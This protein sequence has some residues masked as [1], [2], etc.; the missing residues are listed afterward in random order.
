VRRKSAIRSGAESRILQSVRRSLILALI[1]AAAVLLA[2]AERSLPP[3]V[4]ADRL[5]SG[6]AQWIW[7][8]PDRQGVTPLAFEAARDFE[9]AAPPA[10]ARIHVLADEEYLLH[11]NGVRVGSNRYRP[12]AGVDSYAVAPLLVSGTNRLLLELR[13]GRR[14]GGLLLRL[15]GSDG[16]DIVSGPQWR[17]LLRHRQRH[18]DPAN[19]LKEA[20]RPW[21]WGA[22]PIG[23]WRL[24]EAGAELPLYA[25]AV[26]GEARL[27]PA[28]MG[29]GEVGRPARELLPVRRLRPSS[30]SLGREVTFDWGREVDGYVGLFFATRKWPKA[31]LYFGCEPPS[32]EA[33]P[34]DHALGARGRLLWTSALPRRFRC[35][36][37][38]APEGVRGA[39]VTEVDPDR[40][41]PLLALGAMPAGPRRGVFGL[42]R[43]PPL[44]SPVEHEIRRQLEGLTG[45]V[46]GQPG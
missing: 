22:P 10:E 19:S 40:A 32:P 14:S 9:L 3:R 12:G 31:L 20:R 36:T 41:A 27:L 18:L 16:L 44:V 5:V 28:R 24:P 4:V 8:R 29:V 6:R 45:L 23:R 21:V 17:I 1:L 33:A 42:D 7:A 37:V 46:G 35:L 34:D 26:A 13:S 39:F 11:L 30:P 43:P 15:V 2:V 25:E 38:L